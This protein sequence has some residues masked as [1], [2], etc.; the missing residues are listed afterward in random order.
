[1]RY[2]L[3]EKFRNGLRNFINASCVII[4]KF[5]HYIFF[6]QDK[7]LKHPDITSPAFAVI[8]CQTFFNIQSFTLWSEAL[9]KRQQRI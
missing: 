7:I 1:M 6:I 5:I 4:P 2:L 8:N 3:I 9:E